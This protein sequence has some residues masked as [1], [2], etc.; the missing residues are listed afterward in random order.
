M[1]VPRLLPPWPLL[2]WKRRTAGPRPR[3]SN[4]SGPGTG[5]TTWRIGEGS[6]Q[7]PLAARR[8]SRLRLLDRSRFRSLLLLLRLLR[9]REELRS[10]LRSSRRRSRSRDCSGEASVRGRMFR[11][12]IG[13]PCPREAWSGTYPAT[14]SPRLAPVSRP[15]SRSTPP[16]TH[17]PR[18][19]EEKEALVEN[20]CSRA[21]TQTQCPKATLRNRSILF[22]IE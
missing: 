4:A 21:N 17:R 16:T 7:T 6:Q 12:G 2:V 19:R 10:R 9:S 22:F 5:E 1:P 18:P 11:W 14:A 3:A 20:T 8:T 15:A 13:K